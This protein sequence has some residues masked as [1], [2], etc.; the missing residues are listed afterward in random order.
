MS[1][2]L[3]HLRALSLRRKY[4]PREAYTHVRS[5]LEYSF[6]M[7]AVLT[8]IPSAVGILGATV[9]PHSLF[10]GSA[11]ATQDRISFRSAKNT[12]N[13]SNVSQTQSAESL[14][15]KLDEKRVLSR[16]L[17]VGFIKSVLRI[18]RKPDASSYATAAR[19]HG[20]HQNNSF[21]FVRAHIYHGTIDVAGS[22]LGFAVMINALYV[23]SYLQYR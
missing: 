21:E 17:Y 10:I 6:G 11:L 5:L 12:V 13:L 2:G 15:G 16:R 4:S 7:A 3:K 1:T 18:F 22:L 23:Q 9:M 14:A 20:E 19:N 8:D